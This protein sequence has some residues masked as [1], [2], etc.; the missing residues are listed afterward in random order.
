MLFSTPL[1]KKRMSDT[2]APSTTGDHGSDHEHAH[3]L[4]PYIAVFVA[5]LILLGLAVLVACIPTNDYRLRFFLTA[6]AYTIAVVKAVLII[7]WFM[8]V[9]ESTR[10]T[11]LFAGAS[12]FWLVIMFS[13]TLNDYGSRGMIPQAYKQ[14]LHSVPVKHTE[15]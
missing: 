9:K 1:R 12:F 10:L 7:L 3:S 13:L 14:S 5:L 11:W 6:I 8:H 15:R 2:L 4:T